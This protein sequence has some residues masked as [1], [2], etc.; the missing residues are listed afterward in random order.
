M[1]ETGTNP[2]KEYTAKTGDSTHESMSLESLSASVTTD[3]LYVNTSQAMAETT[4]QT[5]MYIIVVNGDLLVL[6]K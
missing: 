6:K 2:S 5:G 3:A 1:T 4:S